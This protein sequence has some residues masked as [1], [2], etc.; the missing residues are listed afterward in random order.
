MGWDGETAAYEGLVLS[1]E[2]AEDTEILMRNV[3]NSALLATGLVV[4]VL[5]RFFAVSAERR[6]F[7]TEQSTRCWPVCWKAREARFGGAKRDY[8][9]V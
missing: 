4:N 2:D 5:W 3:E 8:L 7:P 9:V 6:D 1:T